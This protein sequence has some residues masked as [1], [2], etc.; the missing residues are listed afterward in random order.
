MRQQLQLLSLS[1]ANIDTP[2]ADLL[3][4]RTEMGKYGLNPE[5]LVFIVNQDVYYALIQDAEFQNLNEVGAVATKLK[6]SVGSIFGTGVLVSDEF[7]TAAVGSIGA[8]VVNR[9][10]YVLPRLRGIKVEQD[11]EVLEQ[12]RVLVATQSLGFTELFAGDGSGVEP[13]IS[14]AFST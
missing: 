7:D 10:N 5:D 8:F 3:A 2:A 1:L 6:G 4:A 9:A 12:R 13:S 14:I 11:Y